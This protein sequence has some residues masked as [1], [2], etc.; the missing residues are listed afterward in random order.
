M[1]FVSIDIET[2]GLNPDI[3]QILEFGCVAVENWQI[4]DSFRRTI[5]HER[6]EG[7]A[8][9]LA[10]NKDL[11]YEIA[12][13]KQNEL[14]KGEIITINQLTYD[15][16]DWVKEIKFIPALIEKNKLNCA[17]K[18]FGA[19]DLQFLKKV[20]MWN[21]YFSIS[22]KILDPAILYFDSN[23]DEVLPSLEEC[24]KRSGLFFDNTVKHR[25][26]ADAK[27]VADLLIHKLKPNLNNEKYK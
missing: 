24:K 14:N 23:V 17:G 1:K 12:N 2:T 9:E 7:N 15:F 27:D 13:C 21:N 26:D 8:F 25:A 20:E 10:M 3:D 16:F 5:W 4:I 19:F 18:N 11:L 6:I 22:S